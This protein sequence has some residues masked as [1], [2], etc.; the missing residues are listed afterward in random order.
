MRRVV[1]AAWLG[2]LASLITLGQ[3][4]ASLPGIEVVS[5][6]PGDPG[7]TAM[8]NRFSAE[9]F[10]LINYALMSLIE[11]AY[12]L[13][14]YQILNAPG[15]LRSERWTLEVKT[16]EPTNTGQKLQLLQPLLADRFQLKVHRETRMLAVYSLVVAKGGPKLRKPTEDGPGWSR[17][18]NQIIGRKYDIARLARDLSG[19]LNIP[20]LDKTD[21][22]GI[23]DIDLMWSSDPGQKDFRDVRDSAD[24]P[25]P[26]PNRP[27]I[28]TAIKEQL[29]LELKAEKGPVEVIVIDHVEKPSPN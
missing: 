9:R 20:V 19:N 16:T 5:V 17:Y 14:E 24:I 2:S 22:K 23:Y 28:F 11:S 8:N 21:L 10:T 3:S 7:A 12:S 26:D 29:G 25:A 13:R 4:T 18:G 27:V 15:W 6:K 1:V